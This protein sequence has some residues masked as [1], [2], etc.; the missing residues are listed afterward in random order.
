[1]EALKGIYRSAG[2][3]DPRTL[4]QSGNVVYRTDA[5]DLGEI[6]RR[7]E[8]AIEKSFGF[9][10]AVIQRTAGE[11]R[12]AIAANPFGRDVDG[13]KLLVTFLAAEPPD[14]AEERLHSSYSGPEQ[15]RVI[16]R[17]MFVYYP[18]GMGRSKLTPATVD[19]ALRVTGTGR[20]WNTVKKL[21]DLAD[22]PGGEA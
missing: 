21:M 12:S 2:L 8:S 17:E 19:K 14:G 9:R 5:S 3:E 1:M 11:W 7:V 6:G 22:S 16:G 10:P 20:N 18:D 4:L 13:S 15:I